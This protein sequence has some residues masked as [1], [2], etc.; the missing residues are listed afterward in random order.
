MICLQQYLGVGYVYT[1]SQNNLIYV[2]PTATY[3]CIVHL[4]AMFCTEN[5]QAYK[6]YSESNR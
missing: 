6:S 5:Y 2:T 1:Q 4:P 3:A